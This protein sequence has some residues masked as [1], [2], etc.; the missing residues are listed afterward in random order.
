MA[1]LVATL[2]AFIPAEAGDVGDGA[3]LELAARY[4]RVGVRVPCLGREVQT[5]HI[6][7]FG[8]GADDALCPPVVLLHGFDGSSLEFRRL[9]PLLA[10]SVQAWAVDL[11][12]AGFSDHGIFKGEPDLIAG[13]A[14]RT[15]H[16]YEFWKSNI[17][18][19]MAV[20][21][22]SLGGA[23]AMDF[24]L[25]YPEAVDCIILMDSQGYV[26]GIG[27]MSQLPRPL[28]SLGVQVLRT[29][30]LRQLAN[31]MAYYDKETY[32]S[33][34]AMKVGRLHTFLPGWSD[35]NVSFMRSG[36]YSLSP[37]IKDVQ[38]PTLILW[39]RDDGILD[40]SYAERFV[41]DITC[42]KLVWVEQCGHSPHLE[43]PQVVAEAILDFLK[44]HGAT[45]EHS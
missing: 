41:E 3:A 20:A 13:P 18:R 29:V 39:G 21:G 33:E 37:R 24:A 9:M 4:D 16:L 11:V 6:R 22:I 5:A 12:G 17:G 23:A 35:A 34:D 38:Q 1:T 2:P 44:T 40:P 30:A 31:T 36:G 32:A 26:D 43:Q 7:P 42:S 25:A 27:A 45:K 10:D 19:P 8:K 28:Q 14:Q 15:E